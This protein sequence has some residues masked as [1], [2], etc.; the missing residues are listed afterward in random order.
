MAQNDYKNLRP[1]RCAKL[2][3]KNGWEFLNREGS[4]ATYS[5]KINGTIHFLQVIYNSKTIH[6]SNA[7]NMIEKSDIPLQLW[8]K[9][10]K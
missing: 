7:K 5:K 10:C 1:E 9:G 4:H 8:V 3:E 2:L 6:P